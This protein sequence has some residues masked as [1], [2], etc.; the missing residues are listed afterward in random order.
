MGPFLNRSGGP[1]RPWAEG[2]VVELSDDGRYA[3]IVVAEAKR[4]IV[5][6]ELWSLDDLRPVGLLGEY[7]RPDG[8]RVTTVLEFSEQSRRLFV[9]V[10]RGDDRRATFLNLDPLTRLGE[11][12]FKGGALGPESNEGDYV[13]IGNEVFDLALPAWRCQ[14]ESVVMSPG[15]RDS[16]DGELTIAA[17]SAGWLAGFYKPAGFFG[18]TSQCVVWNTSTGKQT[19]LGGPNWSSS[20]FEERTCLLKGDRLFIASPVDNSGLV[21]VVRSE[22]WD[23]SKMTLIR[24]SDEERPQGQSSNTITIWSDEVGVSMPPR[25][26]GARE[27]VRRPPLAPIN[28]LANGAKVYR[29]WAWADGRVED[30][31]A[32]AGI[33]RVDPMKDFVFHSHGERRARG[34]G[35]SPR[36]HARATVRLLERRLDEFDEASSADSA[37]GAR[38]LLHRLGNATMLRSVADGRDVA[39]E[40]APVINATGQALGPKARID[41]RQRV[42]VLMPRVNASRD[43]RAAPSASPPGGAWDVSSGRRL[44]VIPDGR[45]LLGIDPAGEWLLTV[46]E[47]ASELIVTELGSGKEVRRTRP[48]DGAVS[49]SGTRVGASG[50]RLAFVARG[51]LYLWDATAN[52]PVAIRRGT[53]HSGQVVSVAQHTTAGLVATGGDDGTVVVRDRERGRFL[54]LLDEHPAGVSALA[55]SPDG[56]RLVSASPPTP[57]SRAGRW[58]DTVPTVILWDLKTF[59]PLWV[60]RGGSPGAGVVAVDHADPRRLVVAT[61]DGRL[62]RLDAATGRFDASSA[63]DPSG[64]Q[65]YDRSPGGTR[66]MVLT[67]RRQVQIRDAVTL[68]PVH[69]WEPAADD[70]AAA[71]F[72]DNVVVTGGRAIRLRDAATGRTLLTLDPVDGPVR[73]LAVQAGSEQVVYSGPGDVVHRIDLGELQ[74]RL[75]QL[76]LA[77]PEAMP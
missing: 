27:G 35:A 1:A 70:Q 73:Q 45:R 54:R 77:M 20:T 30:V 64:V 53:E 11:V 33:T 44:A 22:L 6:L 76:N 57:G 42:L 52:R 17:T 4:D 48:L 67:Q 47:T 59:A 7:P 32:L 69:K 16:D 26:D 68:A 38:W 56:T 41:P 37:A 55:F 29:R 66:V 2:D 36:A 51:A 25:A 31:L 10:K 39:L 63:T 24:R 72:H 60:Y 19:R 23:L 8:Q 34:F 58:P 9:L 74:N 71:F 61:S 40:G 43:T 14:L 65:S 21:P 3:V 18:K 5:E 15:I 50:D 49:T 13:L 46:D 62:L 75:R 12:P 28:P